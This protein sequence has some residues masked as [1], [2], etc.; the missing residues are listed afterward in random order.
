MKNI[1]DQYYQKY[2]AWYSR[3][4]FTY[5][6]ELEALKKVI[7]QEGKGLE[8]GVGTGR[9]ASPLGIKYGIDPSRNM[10]KIARTRGIDARLNSGEH[11]VFKDGIFDFVAIIITLAFTRKPYIVLKEAKRVLKKNGKIVIGIIDRNSFLGKFY[12]RK[13]G[14]FYKHA[15]LLSI[16]E[17]TDLLKILG[18]N[19]FSY[20]QSVF[21]YPDRINSVQKPRKGFGKGGFVVISAR[22]TSEFNSSILR[23]FKQYEKIRLLFK[24]YGY[25]MEKE[26]QRV[27]RRG[28][29][30]RE[31][32]LDVGTGP[33]RMAY[34][35]ALAGF[36]LC[37]VDISQAAQDVARLYA[38]KYGVLSKIKFLNMDAQGLRFSNNSFNTV[39]S[40]NLLHDVKNPNRVV[41]EMIR[42]CKVNGK[43]IISDLNKKGKSLVN[44]VYRI[45]KEVHR[46]KA[47]DLDRVVADR[48]R[49]QHI[50]F[51]KHID[52]FITTFVGRKNP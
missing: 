33:G 36:R 38:K 24:R 22:K 50:T 4:K 43:I 18:F 39:F 17:V 52:G 12:Q 45:N 8:I 11:L 26:R 37:S 10:I 48:F 31:P 21:N 2:D 19:K 25:D 40:A 27:F 35:L 1:F 5:L 51:N 46:S 7:P 23:K 47:I 9:F 49:A 20:Y 29:K 30:I 3:N 41:D 34:T 14:I 16:E 28:G 32:I 6:S 42:V 15:N 44:K 13:K